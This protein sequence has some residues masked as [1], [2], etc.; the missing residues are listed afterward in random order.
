MGRDQCSERIFDHHQK[1]ARTPVDVGKSYRELYTTKSIDLD[2][3]LTRWVHVEFSRVRS[4]DNLT[5]S[6]QL[7]VRTTPSNLVINRTTRRPGRSFTMFGYTIAGHQNIGLSAAGY[8]GITGALVGFLDPGSVANSYST[9]SVSGKDIVGGLV[10]FNDTGSR[11]TQS[12]AAGAVSGN[13]D[14]GGLIGV[15]FGGI[16]QDSSV[17]AVATISG[18]SNVGGLVGRNEGVLATISQSTATATV[19]GVTNVGGL[20]GINN[21]GTIT[22]ATT[23]GT[24]NGFTNVGGLVGTNNQGVISESSSTATVNILVNPVGATNV[25]GLVG[26]NQSNSVVTQSTRPVRSAHHQCRRTVGTNSQSTISQSTAS[27]TVTA[28]SLSAVWSGPTLKAAG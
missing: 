22:L 11:V 26:L 9:G 12:S 27:G 18:V 25:G 15:N 10:G 24:V 2:P 19:N 1:R 17:S 6:G 21:L 8:L 7:T 5:R 13:N 3:P 16:V 23:A 28:T 14:V 4:V 20:V